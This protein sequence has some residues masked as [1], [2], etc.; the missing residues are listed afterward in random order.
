M[1][2]AAVVTGYTAS[3]TLRVTVRDLS[4]LRKLIQ[5]ATQSGAES[6]DRLT[7]DLKDERAVRARALAQAASQARSGAEALAS[8]LSLRLGKLLRIE[9]VQPVVISPA[10]S[11]G[12]GAVE[13]R[14][15]MKRLSRRARF[16][17]TPASIWFTRS[18]IGRSEFVGQRHALA[19]RPPHFKPSL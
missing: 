9:E 2:R 15:P 11:G 18:M 7:F 12:F 17:F 16:R 4:Q 13:S 14:C 19:A 3:N 1:A 8:S 5:S 10:E 6:V